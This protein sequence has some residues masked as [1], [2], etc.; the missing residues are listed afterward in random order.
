MLTMNILQQ[1]CI[2]SLLVPY[3]RSQYVSFQQS[4][5]SS[6]IC[7]NTSNTSLVEHFF[8]L[9]FSEF[10][11]HP[12]V[13]VCVQMC[14][15]QPTYCYPNGC[16]KKAE[17]RRKAEPVPVP[18]MQVSQLQTDKTKPMSFLVDDQSGFME[19]LLTNKYVAD[20]KPD[21][22]PLHDKESFQELHR[23]PFRDRYQSI[24][25]YKKTPKVHLRYNLREQVK[26]MKSDVIKIEKIDVSKTRWPAGEKKQFFLETQNEE[27]TGA[28]PNK[29]FPAVM[30]DNGPVQYQSKFFKRDLTKKYAPPE[31]NIDEVEKLV[32][33]KTFSLENLI[34][35]LIESS[36]GPLVN[37][38]ELD[39]NVNLDYALDNNNS[40]TTIEPIT[41]PNK[42]SIF[43]K[44]MMII[45][46]ETTNVMGLN[47]TNQNLDMNKYTDD[48]K[49]EMFKNIFNDMIASLS[50][51]IEKNN[52]NSM[53]M[54]EH[55]LGH[56]VYDKT[57]RPEAP[58]V[59]ELHVDITTSDNGRGNSVE[60]ASTGTTEAHVESV[61]TKR[62]DFILPK[63]SHQ[64][65]ARKLHNSKTN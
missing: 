60:A 48:T 49:N 24:F 32:T 41:L 56:K 58:T 25:K 18:Q 42:R 31:D 11:N 53:E 47:E 39:L 65:L 45:I 50:K 28:N 51:H 61:T 63:K 33:N 15:E 5:P 27:K 23:D 59:D 40:A 36:F 35:N 26:H 3:A 30:L 1:F 64:R 34:E 19:N 22:K 13:C 4:A 43:D 54:M 12:P 7:E 20:N 8:N 16:Y 37:D 38:T 29:F 9:I 2:I 10:H 21:R 57:E 44:N 14:A 17:A 55:V 52:N 46:N 6:N 62:D